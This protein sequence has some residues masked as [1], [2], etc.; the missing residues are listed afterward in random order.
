VQQHIR[1]HIFNFVEINTYRGDDSKVYATVRRYFFN[2][3]Y[4]DPDDG[5]LRDMPRRRLRY[6]STPVEDY[7]FLSYE[8]AYQRLSGI[9]FEVRYSVLPESIVVEDIDEKTGETCYRRIPPTFVD[10]VNGKWGTPSIY[11]DLNRFAQ[12]KRPL[13][14]H[15]LKRAGLVNG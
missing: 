11:S 5:I 3:L 2:D 15:E 4:V 8:R 13:T 7:I 12:A 1:S 10:V 14:T 6:P 9:W